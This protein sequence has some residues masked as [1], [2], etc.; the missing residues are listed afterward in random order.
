[1]KSKKEMLRILKTAEGEII[2]DVTGKENGRGAYL[3]FSKD[4]L[5]KAI[6]TKG[7]ERSFQMKI[8]AE[9][10]ERLKEEFE[11]IGDE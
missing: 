4:C 2:P 1:M 6:K 5:E 7:L 11:K 10:Y 3:C 9:V 8:P